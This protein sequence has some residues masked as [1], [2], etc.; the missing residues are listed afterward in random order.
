MEYAEAV[1]EKYLDSAVALHQAMVVQT[2]P[3]LGILTKWIV[4]LEIAEVI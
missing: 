3:A 4:P 1:L 2:A